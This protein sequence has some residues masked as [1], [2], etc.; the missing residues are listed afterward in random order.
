MDVDLALV[1]ALQ[2]RELLQQ[3]SPSSPQVQELAAQCEKLLAVAGDA[4][5]VKGAD[6]K[7]EQAWHD[8]SE[9]L[10]FFRSIAAADE[11]LAKKKQEKHEPSAVESARQPRAE[12]AGSD[13]AK[14][15][16]HA[17]SSSSRRRKKDTNDEVVAHNADPHVAVQ[18]NLETLFSDWPHADLLDTGLAPGPAP[19]SLP[20][21]QSFPWG[22]SKAGDAFPSTNPGAVA[23]AAEAGAVSRRDAGAHRRSKARSKGSRSARQAA[24]DASSSE[25][26]SS[27][28]SRST[29]TRSRDSRDS[30][31]S[32]RRHGHWKER[33]RSHQRHAASEEVLLP[34]P[35]AS[36]SAELKAATDCCCCLRVESLRASLH[37]PTPH[38][39]FRLAIELNLPSYNI[40]RYEEGVSVADGVG[41]ISNGGFQGEVTWEQRVSFFVKT[42]RRKKSKKHKDS[43]SSAS[44]AVLALQQQGQMRFL[45]S[46]P[47]DKGPSL[48]G[49]LAL[50]SL[51]SPYSSN[52][53][54]S[55][56]CTYCCFLCE[57]S[58]WL[59]CDGFT[60]L[61][62]D[63]T[64]YHQVPLHYAP[65]STECGFLFFSIHTEVASAARGATGSAAASRPLSIPGSTALIS[66]DRDEGDDEGHGL[67]QHRRAR[68]ADHRGATR[69]SDLLA[70]YE[71]AQKESAAL[72][73]QNGAL[74]A[75]I[76]QQQQ[77]L[78]QQQ[79]Q[80]QAL[81]TQVQQ[82]NASLNDA[83]QRL[84]AY[85][86]QYQQQLHTLHQVQQQR[87]AAAAQAAAEKA[88]LQREMLQLEDE[89][90]AAKEEEERQQELV[91]KHKKEVDR[92]DREL[93]QEVTRRKAAENKAKKQEERIAELTVLL[94]N[95][96][97]R[98]R[99]ERQRTEELGIKLEAA[100]NAESSLKAELQASQE[101]AAEGKRQLLSLTWGLDLP[102]VF[103]GLPPSLPKGDEEERKQQT[104]G[105][106]F[107][108]LSDT[109]QAQSERVK[110]SRQP[111]ATHALSL[112]ATTPLWNDPI[113]LRR[114]NPPSQLS[115]E[116]GKELLLAIQK[117]YT[118]LM[119]AEVDFSSEKVMKGVLLDTNFLRVEWCSSILGGGSV[120]P[121]DSPSHLS[122]TIVST[123]LFALS[124]TS[125]I[126]AVPVITVTL[127][128]EVFEGGRVMLTGRPSQQS[129]GVTSDSLTQSFRL[130]LP[131]PAAVFCGPLPLTG[132]AF[133]TQWRSLELQED[134]V[135]VDLS[136]SHLRSAVSLLALGGRFAVLPVSEE[137][138]ARLPDARRAGL[139]CI[140][141]SGV[142]PSLDASTRTL[143]R[144][145]VQQCSKGCED[146][147]ARMES[148]IPCLIELAIKQ[149]A[150][151]MAPQHLSVLPYRAREANGALRVRCSD[152]ALRCSVL[153]ALLQ[154]L[155]TPQQ[156]LDA[157]EA[158]F[159]HKRR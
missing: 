13:S 100:A 69:D 12:R 70:R 37:L 42:P 143:R 60:Y 47:D 3:H 108:S 57:Y 56:C 16:R 52:T 125:H 75:H 39:S 21:N 33:G 103:S 6:P 38:N 151:S 40:E 139:T 155:M 82:M 19:S 138:D 79:H 129:R 10:V 133:S 150:S 144:S 148:G 158:T 159:A 66:Q 76:Q 30:T 117:G 46:C 123:A 67:H 17:S 152:T 154:Q 2:L 113:I 31:L 118:D 54:A 68:A 140:H 72:Q 137:A 11:D 81:H 97:S 71:G 95:A 147:F 45:I 84:T 23:A 83:F 85:E 53:S 146:E 96:R 61:A 4:L 119:H 77:V 78:M 110:T 105:R 74:Q 156:L 41:S 111:A 27:S 141:A 104:D 9:A 91:R 157:A 8:L 49:D 73:Q 128:Q 90:E 35:Q 135:L 14:K 94:N 86:A 136:L 134:A 130:K 99:H 64:T 25:T 48:I 89:L 29:S 98:I 18:D 87:D 50:H 24:Q 149:N 153:D 131:L 132:E 145:R 93:Q 102:P 34:A 80:L 32:N 63:E 124:V 65:Q 7:V 115:E 62:G 51:L 26:S 106:I 22:E 58:R 114:V 55:W 5:K 101:A 88:K 107:H 59:S 43:S 1:S 120:S 36:S 20:L 142:F 121:E 15:H 109:E 126:S 92:L 127:E 116:C 44:K 28:A 122:G 112:V